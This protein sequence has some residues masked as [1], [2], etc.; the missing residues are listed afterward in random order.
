MGQPSDMWDVTTLCGYYD[1]ALMVGMSVVEAVLHV[2]SL[3][4]GGQALSLLDHNANN[5]SQGPPYKFKTHT[6]NTIY[7]SQ[8]TTGISLLSLVVIFLYYGVARRLTHTQEGFG[9]LPSKERQ[10]YASQCCKL[11]I[12]ALGA[13]GIVAITIAATSN[14]ALF[15]MI[16]FLDWKAEEDT[17]IG[18]ATQ[19]TAYASTCLVLKLAQ[20]LLGHWWALLHSHLQKN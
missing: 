17:M 8:V 7:L 13:I 11:L 15:M 18:I 5:P 6:A 2:V 10:T 9:N 3:Y 14:G 16:E 12:I 1:I 19:T 4:Q 20:A